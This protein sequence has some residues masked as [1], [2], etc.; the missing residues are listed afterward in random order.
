MPRRSNATNGDSSAIVPGRATGGAE[1][2]MLLARSL[3]QRFEERDDIRRVRV[4][5]TQVRHGRAWL[6][7]GRVHDPALEIVRPGVRHS[8]PGDTRP[9]GDAGQIGAD[10][11]TR[12][13]HA[14]NRVAATAAL[15]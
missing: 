1:V 6:E 14:W 3:F 4:V 11:A 2:A 8:A 13:R 7:G 5:Q 15:L 10:R 9:R 12:A